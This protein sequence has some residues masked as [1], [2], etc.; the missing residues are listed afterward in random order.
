MAAVRHAVLLALALAVTA[1]TIAQAQQDLGGGIFR[2]GR[3]RA[4]LG[5]VN[6]GVGFQGSQF[7]ELGRNDV[8]IRA[9]LTAAPSLRAVTK[10]PCPSC[11]GGS[12]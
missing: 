2:G 10:R 5:L 12:A 6:G 7:P 1:P 4:G 8:D 9:A 3:V 11:A